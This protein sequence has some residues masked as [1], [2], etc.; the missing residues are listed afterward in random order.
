M[1][2]IISRLFS[3]SESCFSFFVR[4][5]KNISRDVISTAVLTIK[6]V[7][8][9]D[10][11]ATF[12]CIGSGSYETV[13][14]NITLIQRSEWQ[15][16]CLPFITGA[17]FL[18]LS[19]PGRKVFWHGHSTHGRVAVLSVCCY[20]AQVLHH[21]HRSFIPSLFVTDKTQKRWGR[22]L[23][24]PMALENKPQQCGGVRVKLAPWWLQWQVC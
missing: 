24:R 20:A 10:F 3:V 12:K 8:A 1:Q 17:V 21:W 23:H 16:P 13:S 14:K 11:Q 2:G 19:P 18:T 9:K 22:T 4:I 7:S 5:M 6:K 15:Q